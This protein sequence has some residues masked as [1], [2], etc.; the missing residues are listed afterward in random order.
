MP[1][2]EWIADSVSR[3]EV[4]GGWLYKVSDALAFVPD[5]DAAVERAAE[6]S[7]AMIKES[8]GIYEGALKGA[9]L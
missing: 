1:Q 6:L 3:V 8:A 4:P 5:P 9:D 2:W 7:R